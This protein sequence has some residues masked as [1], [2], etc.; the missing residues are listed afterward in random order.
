M[1]NKLAWLSIIRGVLEI[2][3]G[4]TSNSIHKISKPDPTNALT[5]V[6]RRL[7]L[8]RI[9][10]KLLPSTP[11]WLPVEKLELDGSPTIVLID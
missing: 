7:H 6:P 8:G 9:F 11:R 10:Q 4:Q 2:I 3:R 5:F 1:V